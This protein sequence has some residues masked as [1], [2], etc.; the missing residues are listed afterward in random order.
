MTEFRD[1]VVIER[2]LRS[3]VTVAVIGLSSDPERDSNR[4]ASYLQNEGYTVLPINPQETE[5][6]G[7]KAHASITDVPADVTIDCA[8]LFRRAEFVSDHVD[9]ILA[10][11]NVR[12]VW[13]QYD[14][15]DEAAATRARERGLDVV[16]DAC[17]LVERRAIARRLGLDWT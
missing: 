12:A 3:A 4:V 15:V 11:G 9:E 17:M 6:L 10:R 14:V 13:M 8:C 5:I 7:E 2:I 1:P 16:M